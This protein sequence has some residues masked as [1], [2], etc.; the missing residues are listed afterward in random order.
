MSAVPHTKSRELE[1]RAGNFADSSGVEVRSF[2]DNSQTRDCF[3]F[4]LSSLPSRRVESCAAVQV[5]DD[6]DRVPFGRS[7]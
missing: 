1:E 7:H 3:L 6:P 4:K 5:S 2:G